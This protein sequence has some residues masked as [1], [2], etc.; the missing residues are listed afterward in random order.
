MNSLFLFSLLDA[1]QR[2]S[3]Q[4]RSQ[5]DSMTAVKVLSEH[6]QSAEL[7]VALRV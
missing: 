1:V 3:K 6:S 4:S 2:L 5:V 7:V